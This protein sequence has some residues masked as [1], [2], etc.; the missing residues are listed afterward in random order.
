MISFHG[1]KIGINFMEVF[2]FNSFE[3]ETKKTLLKTEVDCNCGRLIFQ[4]NR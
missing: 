4:S 1:K 3:L 2:L